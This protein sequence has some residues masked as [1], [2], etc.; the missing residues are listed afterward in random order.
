MI[1]VVVVGGGIAGLATAW[2]LT[3]RAPPDLDLS[4]RVVEEERDPGGKARSVADDG[5]V[6]E[7][8][9]L[10]FLGHV[11]DSHA[12][13]DGIGLAG[14]T[15]AAA[16][17]AARRLVLHEG[18]LRPLPSS[19]R[20]LLT[21]DL[22]SWRARLRLLREPF[23]GRAKEHDESVAAFFS[24]RLG[25]EVVPALVEPFVTGIWAGDPARLSVLGALPRLALLEREHGSLTRGALAAWRARRRRGAGVAAPALRSFPGGMGEL[26]RA[27]ADDLG[28]ALLRGCRAA[29]LARD[30][31]GYA[32]EVEGARTETLRADA[33]VLA[34]PVDAARAL[35]DPVDP[36][37]GATLRTLPHAGVAV[38]VATWPSDRVR[39]PLDA[40]GFTCRRAEDRRILGAIFH[41]SVF[42]E[43][44]PDG[45]A[46]LRATLGGVRAPRLLDRS[47]EDLTATAVRELRDILGIDGDPTRTTVMRH[48]R[49][50]PQYDRGH[51]GRLAAIDGKLRE[52]PNLFL[53]G[54]AYRGT[55]V[56]DCI[57]N[58]RK[59]ASHVLRQVLGEATRAGEG[60]G[61]RGRGP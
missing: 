9:P 8:G 19:P 2:Y 61:E 57:R 11:P 27:I 6:L 43:H 44:A 53:T 31:S 51:L 3:R 49:G 58:G 41:S 25:E 50:M 37:L 42:P 15:I 52:H 18:R 22:L 26:P 48:P 23:V 12:L 45:T 29:T 28:D 5:V 13:L 10:A 14:R 30:G 4:V 35:L 20:A 47:D 38:V 32:V 24:R 17:S 59:T 36:D 7:R 40:F 60:R 46:L 39:H 21:S 54:A 55:S 16:P 1:R 56:D 33:L 34:T